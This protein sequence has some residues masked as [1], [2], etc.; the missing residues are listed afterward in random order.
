M[1]NCET[2][3]NAEDGSFLVQQMESLLLINSNNIQKKYHGKRTNNSLRAQSVKRKKCDR[4]GKQPELAQPVL[5]SLVRMEN[6][7]SKC[8]TSPSYDPIRIFEGAILGR[9]VVSSLTG[10]RPRARE[11][12][13]T[14]DLG[15]GYGKCE[16]GVSRRHVQVI[17]IDLEGVLVVVCASV[18]NPLSIVSGEEHRYF[19]SGS[20][21]LLK[22]GDVLIFDT[23][24][25]RPQHM[26][27]LTKYD[28]K[29][30]IAGK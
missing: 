2:E 29:G 6:T 12:G 8:L 28:E 19:D 18:K 15:I 17:S 27:T 11:S 20:L 4:L 10:R 30:Q 5:Y 21:I 3:S 26:F 25:K 16:E 13:H 9:T 1:A 22:H 7:K 23:Y 14:I 24:M